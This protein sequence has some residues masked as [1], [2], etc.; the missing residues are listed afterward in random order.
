MSKW[1]DL[2]R[3]A[4]MKTTSE[5]IKEG[6]G[7]V[8][9][10]TT[11]VISIDAEELERMTLSEL[12]NRVGHARF[13][14]RTFKKMDR[15]GLRLVSQLRN[16][17]AQDLRAYYGIGYKGTAR[18]EDLLHDYGVSLKSRSTKRASDYYDPALKKKVDH[19]KDKELR[20]IFYKEC[21]NMRP[22]GRYA[23]ACARMGISSIEE[24]QKYSELEL[25][26]NHF[27]GLRGIVIVRKLLKNIGLR[28]KLP[29]ELIQNPDIPEEPKAIVYEEVKA[30]PPL[31]DPEDPTDT[32][33]EKPT[34]ALPDKTLLITAKKYSALRASAEYSFIFEPVAPKEYIINKFDHG[35]YVDRYQSCIFLCDELYMFRSHDCYTESYVFIF[36]S[37]GLKEYKVVEL[38]AKIIDTDFKETIVGYFIQALYTRGLY[39]GD[40]S[41]PSNRDY[42]E[43]YLKMLILK[44]LDTDYDSKNN[45]DGE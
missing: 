22:A 40:L 15:N 45:E 3:A 27:F 31:C 42:L 34:V 4:I 36:W 35:L 10:K 1:L 24:F 30:F 44:D 43:Y 23:N 25:L 5:D 21:N 6:V 14:G 11:S 8:N 19:R 33:K 37:R 20:D 28:F 9:K 13:D 17:S 26:N 18:L 7:N 41:I 12:K 32:I 39:L 16:L 29:S 38:A 2:A